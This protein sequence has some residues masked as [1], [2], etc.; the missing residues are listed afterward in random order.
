MDTISAAEA[1][2]RLGTSIPRVKRAL[3]RLAPAQPGRRG[4][5]SITP[6][7]MQQLRSE[8]GR[9]PVIGGLSRSEVRCLAAL[10]RAP[11]GLLSARAVARRAGISPTSASSAL[12][13]LREA[14]LVRWQRER[15]AAGRVVEVDVVRAAVD[16]PRWA[17]IAPQLFDCDIPE[18]PPE[19]ERRV[20]RHLR[21]LFWNTPTHSSTSRRRRRTSRAGSSRAV[22][23]RASMGAANLPG[24]AWRSAASARGT[25]PRARALALNLAKAADEHP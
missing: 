15:V 24:D 13:R 17:S 10:A 25:D 14:G 5:V 7:Q 3:D 6:V 4:R 22:T 16:S 2:R 18:T 11:R 19:H 20:P 9:T 21:H 1:A 12:R 8:L 23:S